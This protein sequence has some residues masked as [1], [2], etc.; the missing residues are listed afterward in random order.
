MDKV[1]VNEAI[2]EWLDRKWKKS[3]QNIGLWI[4]RAAALLLFT[5]LI[6]FV[7]NSEGWH[8]P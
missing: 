5:G 4:L 6:K 3:L 7:L 2:N 1:A 8:K